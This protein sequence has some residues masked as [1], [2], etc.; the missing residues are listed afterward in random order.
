MHQELRGKHP[1]YAILSLHKIDN[2][3]RKL[4]F[5]GFSGNLEALSMARTCW[6]RPFKRGFVVDH[7]S[8]AYQ[9]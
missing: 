9:Y 8:H 5:C 3:S 4:F 6:E 1:N 7:I 2:G